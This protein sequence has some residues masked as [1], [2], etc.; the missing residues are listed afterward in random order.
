MKKRNGLLMKYFVLKPKGLGPHAR[1]SRRAMQAYAMSIVDEN[2]LLSKDLFSW[3][4]KEEKE[5][6][7]KELEEEKTA[8][9]GSDI[10]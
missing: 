3:A 9:E 7:R 1:A 4:D 2:K 5:A 10:G 6:I 8:P